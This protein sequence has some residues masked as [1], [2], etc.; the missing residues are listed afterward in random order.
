MDPSIPCLFEEWSVLAA[1]L[2]L[3]CG[4]AV[5]VLDPR[6]FAVHD[7]NCMQAPF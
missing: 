2:Q 5:R 3:T 7:P 6:G 4:Y 1:G